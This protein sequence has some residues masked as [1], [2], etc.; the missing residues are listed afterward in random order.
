M[1]ESKKE[2]FSKRVDAG[3]RTYFFDVKESAE[4]TKY[5][6]I[7]E[8]RRTGDSP[9]KHDR[10]MVFGEH[11]PAFYQG[12]KRAIAFVTRR[13]AGSGSYAEAARREFPR[14]Y[15]SWTEDEDSG[16]ADAYAQGKTTTELADLFQ[17]K[18]SA[19]ASRLR[20]LALGNGQE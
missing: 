11:I 3:S 9:S 1:G 10:V 20:K 17:R 2:L 4:G 6:V 18:P 12:L 15:A 16:L 19:I 5:L 14:A 13:N 7:S 8:A